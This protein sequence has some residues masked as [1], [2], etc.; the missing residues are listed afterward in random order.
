LLNPDAAKPRDWLH[1]LHLR[2]VCIE[3]RHSASSCS[4]AAL[5]KAGRRRVLSIEPGTAFEGRPLCSH[6]N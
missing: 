5:A 1:A 4:W 6:L 2:A 3:L